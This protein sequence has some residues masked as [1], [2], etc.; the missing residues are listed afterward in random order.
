MKTIAR[1]SYLLSSYPLS[2]ARTS[3]SPDSSKSSSPYLRAVLKGPSRP[4][5]Q[6]P[7]L[8]PAANPYKPNFSAAAPRTDKLGKDINTGEKDWFKNY[9]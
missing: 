9:E 5:S 4:V 2:A 8:L 3:G 6:N 7:N 1:P